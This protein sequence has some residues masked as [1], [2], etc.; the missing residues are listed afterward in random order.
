MAKRGKSIMANK[1]KRKMKKL[2]S[3]KKEDKLMSKIIVYEN[4]DMIAIDK[5]NGIASQ[6]GTNIDQHIDEMVT[7]YIRR[8]GARQKSFLL[9]RLDQYA[10]GIMILGKNIQYARSFSGL[11]MEN[12]IKKSYIALGQGLP[13]YL[14]NKNL[15]VDISNPTKFL[16]GMIRS[17]LDCTV[18]DHNM[19]NPKVSVMSDQMKFLLTECEKLEM[20]RNKPQYSIIDEIADKK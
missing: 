12:K 20:F 7:N 11:M 19:V 13:K 1:R 8:G 2:I 17:D 10:S 4:S 3:L 18:Y 6:G 16:S 15:P 14:F 5:P 9:H